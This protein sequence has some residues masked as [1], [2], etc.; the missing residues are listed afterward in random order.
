M[1]EAFKGPLGY[2][3]AW[4]LFF[5]G[6]AVL[7]VASHAEDIVPLFTHASQP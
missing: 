4:F 7:Y 2:G 6:I 1:S 3:C 5:S